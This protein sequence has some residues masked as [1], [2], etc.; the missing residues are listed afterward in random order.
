MADILLWVAGILFG[1]LWFSVILLPLFYG[2][3]R[4]IYWILKGV[5]RKVAV[6][7]Y[8]LGPVIWTIILIVNEYFPRTRV[9]LF[10]D[11]GFAYGQWIGVLLMLIR[12]LSKDG[13]R[14]LNKDFLSTVARYSIVS[15]SSP[16]NSSLQNDR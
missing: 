8:V 12:S 16:P 15:S 13:R 11:A 14:D 7:S 9:L 1:A 10:S 6:A 5:L 3:P 2:L 4:S